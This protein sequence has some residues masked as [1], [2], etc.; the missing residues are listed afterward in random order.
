MKELPL[1]CVVSVLLEYFCCNA[2]PLQSKSFMSL[3]AFRVLSPR[4]F[5]DGWVNASYETNPPLEACEAHE[6]PRIC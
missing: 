6:P 4:C 2:H 5:T 1:S 3:G